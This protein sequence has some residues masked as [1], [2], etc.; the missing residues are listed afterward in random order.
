[1]SHVKVNDIVVSI[2][3]GIEYKKWKTRLLKFMEYKKCM[4]P[5]TRETTEKDTDKNA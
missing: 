5:A 4:E 2:F 1:M 3:D